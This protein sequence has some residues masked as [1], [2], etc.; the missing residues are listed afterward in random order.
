MQHPEFIHLDQCNFEDFPPGGTLSFSLQMRKAFGNRIALAGIV[1]DNTP[2]GRWVEKKL[3][4]VNYHFFAIGRIERQSTRPLIPTRL[5]TY[6]LLRQQMR[7]MMGLG[8]RRIFTRTPQF[9]LSLKRSDWESICFCFAGTGNSVGLSRYPFLRWMGSLYEKCLF[10]SLVDN[11]DCILAAADSRAIEATIQRSHGVLR[12]GS[13]KAFPTRFDEKIF[14]PHER[15]ECR[16]RLGLPLDRTIIAV[17]GRLCWVKGWPFVIQTLRH[18]LRVNSS[19]MVIF[20]GDG[21]DRQQMETENCDLIQN[22]EVRITGLVSLSEVSEYLGAADLVMIGS[23]EEGWST[24]MIEALACGK[25]MVTTNISG[26]QDMVL[27]DENGYILFDR[28]PLEAARALDQTLY[29]E[30]AGEKSYALSRQ[31]NLHTLSSDLEALW[32]RYRQ[33]NPNGHT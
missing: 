24:A 2:C 22:G 26:A 16:R 14:H 32:L 18:Y 19:A 10:R 17:N 23:H 15:D 27:P 29:L 4:G 7:N 11:A 33:G 12:P 31:Y 6:Y 20:I 8:V 21:E 28:N 13:I 9:M 30:G 1:T 3:H 25:P 5:V